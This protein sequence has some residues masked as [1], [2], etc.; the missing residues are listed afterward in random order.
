MATLLDIKTRARERADM[1]NSTFISDSEL[2][3]YVNASAQE[4]YDLL[5]GT[6]ADYYVTE[7]AETTVANGSSTLALPAD[8]YKL[9]G[10]DIK[11][12][13]ASGLWQDLK[14]FSFQDRN[15]QVSTPNYTYY[16]SNVKY[17]IAGSQ[18]MLTPKDQAEGIYK[19]WYIPK[20]TLLTL[21]T[22]QLEASM[23]PWDEYVVVDAA[24]KML[25]K[26]ESSTSSLEEQKQ[27]L[28]KR[29][30]TM[31]LDR[32]AAHPEVILPQGY[33]YGWSY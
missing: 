19:L 32:D 20:M 27:A 15:R 4:L 5:V 29:I 9:R 31:A 3:S 11:R 12:S 16:C 25:G 1:E 26:E 8:F 33:N 13:D 18:V 24:I 30:M 6:F 2:N 10:V 14:P 21:D 17:H 22:D 28:K 23:S 7:G